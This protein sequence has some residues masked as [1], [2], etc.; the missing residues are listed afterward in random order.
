MMRPAEHIP[1]AGCFSSV[2]SPAASNGIST[3]LQHPQPFQN[4]LWPL[5]T[6]LD[7]FDIIP[8]IHNISCWCCVRSREA[9]GVADGAGQSKVAVA[10]AEAHSHRSR[11]S[12]HSRRSPQRGRAPLLASHQSAGLGGLRAEQGEL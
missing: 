9:F 4:C 11:H 5:L 7:I 2:L 1:A 3:N 6:M 12:R 8:E 10:E